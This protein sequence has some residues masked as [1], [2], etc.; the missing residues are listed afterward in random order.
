M[1]FVAPLPPERERALAAADLEAEVVLVPP[2]KA[3][4]FKSAEGAVAEA[5]ERD[6]DIVDVD[7]DTWCMTLDIVS[8]ACTPRT[9]AIIPVHLYGRPA[10]IGPIAS[11]ARSRGIAV[12][13]DCAEAHGARYRGAVVDC[14][15]TSH[16]GF[17]CF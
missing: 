3:A 5:D 12:V 10:E 13:E 7:R 17:S 15:V 16:I 4:R 8:R 11:F 1:K 9:K 6:C 2:G 14:E